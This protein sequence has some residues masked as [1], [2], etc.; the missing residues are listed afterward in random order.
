MTKS[1][2]ICRT[3]LLTTASISDAQHTEKLRRIGTVS[4]LKGSP[5]NVDAFVQTLRE[6]GYAEGE[7]ISIERRYTM[8]NIERIPGVLC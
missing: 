8:G 6:L 1:F 7:T 2:A 4:K 3:F 5:P